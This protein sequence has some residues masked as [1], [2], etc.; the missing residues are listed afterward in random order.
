MFG[1]RKTRNSFRPI[2]IKRIRGYRQYTVNHP[3]RLTRNIFV[4]KYIYI[5]MVKFETRTNVVVVAVNVSKNA[6][7]L[8]PSTS[9]FLRYLRRA[10]AGNRIE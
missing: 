5:Y 7:S 3:F 4:H 6:T 1:L 9:I 10:S 8:F 2:I